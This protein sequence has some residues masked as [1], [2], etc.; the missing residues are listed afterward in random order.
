MNKDAI[1]II[2]DLATILGTKLGDAIIALIDKIFPPDG[3]GEL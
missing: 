3:G 2:T 1:P